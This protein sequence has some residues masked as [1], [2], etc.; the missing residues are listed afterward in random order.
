MGERRPSGNEGGKSRFRRAHDF[1]DQ[2]NMASLPPPPEVASSSSASSSTPLYVVKTSEEGGQSLFSSTQS[3]PRGTLLFSD[4]ALFT[5]PQDARSLEDVQGRVKKLG[6][7]QQ[8]AFLSLSNCRSGEKDVSP[9]M[10]VFK[11]SSILPSLGR[12]PFLFSL[13]Q[14]PKLISPFFDI[15]QTNVLPAGPGE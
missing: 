15:N 11:V 6:K 4:S 9:V 3:I 14:A 5:I 10:G 2:T 7:E 1:S 13:L 8:R 12:T